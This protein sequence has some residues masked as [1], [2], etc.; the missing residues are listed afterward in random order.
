MF[1]F[2]GTGILRSK[3][4]NDKFWLLFIEIKH[5]A[6]V[7]TEKKYKSSS[8]VV[9]KVFFIQFKKKRKKKALNSTLALATLNF[10]LSLYDC[11][12]LQ[13]F[14]L[15]KSFSVLRDFS[16]PFH[17]FDE[18]K[19]SLDVEFLGLVKWKANKL[20]N[21]K[22]LFGFPSAERGKRKGEEAASCLRHVCTSC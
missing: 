7:V 5:L 17:S 13:R 11:L 15:W 4:H 10:F 16:Q 3:A 6:G 14:L 8:F 1:F 9:S 18:Q 22:A 20:E 2:L 12:L 19:K 21:L